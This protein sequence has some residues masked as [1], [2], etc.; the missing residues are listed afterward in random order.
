MKKFLAP[1]ALLLGGLLFPAGCTNTGAIIVTGLRVELIA[2]ERAGDGTVTLAWRMV[3]P[4]VT[5][6]LIAEVS[7]KIS[8]NG[9][10]VGTTSDLQP[11]AAP[12]QNHADRT[13][14][15][16]LAGAAAERLIADALSQGSASYRVES[17]LTIQLYGE[18]TEKGNLTGTGSV[19]VTGK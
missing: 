18:M 17:V 4:N 11:M 3:N 2:I 16:T 12:A 1:L 8:L 14:R 15:L 7:H 6:Y 5:P 13:S 9:A 19:K 10:P